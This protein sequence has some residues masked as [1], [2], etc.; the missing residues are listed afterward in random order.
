MRRLL[1]LLPLPAAPFLSPVSISPSSSP[2]VSQH[3]CLIRSHPSS[4]PFLLHSL[5]SHLYILKYIQYYLYPALIKITV[6]IPT[7]LL[8][9][10]LPIFF[11]PL[12][13]TLSSLLS[14]LLLW[15]SRLE[16]EGMQHLWLC[17]LPSRRIYRHVWQS[18]VSMV[19]PSRNP[20]GICYPHSQSVRKNERG[21]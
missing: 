3:S 11:L 15:Q 1:P 9:P 14:L 7:F 18:P 4:P 20:W 21:R 5:F 17:P 12:P 8:F 19:I 13:L 6:F 10:R 16:M 2:P